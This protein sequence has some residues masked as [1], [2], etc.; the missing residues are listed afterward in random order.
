MTTINIDTVEY[1]TDKLSD[2]AKALQAVPRMC[3]CSCEP[4]Q[5]APLV[6]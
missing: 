6:N 1:D 4:I 5:E 3:C 2:E